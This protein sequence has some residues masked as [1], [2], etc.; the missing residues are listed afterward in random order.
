MYLG[1]QPQHVNDLHT[2][3]S[4]CRFV[5]TY[6]KSAVVLQQGSHKVHSR[7]VKGLQNDCA[8]PFE[9][10]PHVRSEAHRGQGLLN[11]GGNVKVLLTAAPLAASAPSTRRMAASCPGA[12]APASEC[13]SPDP[14]ARQL[15][16]SNDSC[17]P[18]PPCFASGFCSASSSPHCSASAC[19]GCAGP[20]GCWEA[21][22]PAGPASSWPAVTASADAGSAG[23][24]PLRL[25]ERS[26]SN[27]FLPW[28]RSMGAA[29]GSVGGTGMGWAAESSEL[30]AG[31]Q[32]AVLSAG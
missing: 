6:S 7:P 25:G 2:S 17:C 28:P 5:I 29:G 18:P 31:L 19:A 4:T 13:G 20:A 1:V 11:N 12:A 15:R 21:S 16:M 23:A 27:S 30:S 3:F 24:I 32:L 8:V 14:S 22:S 10:K 9:D 26:S